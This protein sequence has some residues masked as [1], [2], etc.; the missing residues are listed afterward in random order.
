MF[1]KELSNIILDNYG[2]VRNFTNNG[3]TFAVSVNGPANAPGTAN[4]KGAE[5]SYQQTY[6]F[7]PGL[8]RGL[9]TQ[10]TFTYIDPGKIPN[11]TPNNGPAMAAVRRSM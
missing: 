7:L 2:F 9:G 11:A 6:D 1:Y 8:L 3:Q 5:L 4:I 10:A